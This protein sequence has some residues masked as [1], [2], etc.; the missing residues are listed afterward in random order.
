MCEAREI[1]DAGVEGGDG[2]GEEGE[3]GLEGGDGGGEWGGGG[4]HGKYLVYEGAFPSEGL[5]SM[6]S[7]VVDI[8]NN[9]NVEFL[10]E[11]KGAGLA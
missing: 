10:Q 9:L 11:A 7:S 8:L 4:G 5:R 3:G 6:H 1:L 2:G